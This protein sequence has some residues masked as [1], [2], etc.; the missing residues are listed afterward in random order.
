MS[1]FQLLRS[2]ICLGKKPV[3]VYISILDYFINSRPWSFRL[4]TLRLHLS[5]Y[6]SL[7]SCASYALSSFSSW[8]F[9]NKLRT[10]HALMR[11]T[12]LELTQFLGIPCIN[13]CL[14]LI[15]C[16]FTQNLLR[17]W[18]LLID[19]HV[20]KWKLNPLKRALLVYSV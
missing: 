1:H 4:K 13:S 16:F 9:L 6:G 8:D 17:S 20:L 19:D 15:L 14:C 3:E 5:L 11:A 7:Q 2:K 12:A 10:S 18:F